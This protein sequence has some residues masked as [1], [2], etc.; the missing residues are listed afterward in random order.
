MTHKKQISV[1]LVEDNPGDAWLIKMHL[2]DTDNNF[3]KLTTT[4]T[5]ASAIEYLTS[6]KADAILLD[7]SLPD[8]QGLDTLIKINKFFSVIPVIILTGLD[9]KEFAVKAMQHGAQDYLS[10]NS[11][12]AELL[13]RTIRYSIE[14]K[15]AEEGIREKVIELENFNKLMV[16]REIKMIELKKEINELLK[17]A[18]KKEKYKIV[19]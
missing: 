4:A 3:I 11:I 5:L 15:H 19:E 1:L 2:N 16:G 13:T 7:L 18:G 10:K 17:K 8:S 6:N 14:R 9:D 12:N